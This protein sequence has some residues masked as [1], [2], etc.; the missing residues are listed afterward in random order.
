MAI[1]PAALL[2]GC[3][4]KLPALDPAFPQAPAFLQPVDVPPETRADSCFVKHKEEQQGRRRANLIIN[5]G[6][7][8]ITCVRA[9]GTGTAAAACETQVR[10]SR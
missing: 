3:A 8:W 9:A 6:R 5:A 10:P 1:V 4:A 7:D 2:A